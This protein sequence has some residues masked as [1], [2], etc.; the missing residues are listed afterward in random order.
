MAYATEDQN[1]RYTVYVHVNS[2]A[3]YQNLHI[4][5]QAVCQCVE[6]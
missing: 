4:T 6:L 3:A 1:L 5:S 2:N